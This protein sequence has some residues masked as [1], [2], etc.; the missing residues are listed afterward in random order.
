M[1]RQYETEQT[2][3]KFITPTYASIDKCLRLGERDLWETRLRLAKTILHSVEKHRK[4]LAI[5]LRYQT[6]YK[7]DF[8]K[9]DDLCWRWRRAVYHIQQKRDFWVANVEGL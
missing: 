4:S 1:I 3:G 9:V 8:K 5:L 6:E 2:A 7:L